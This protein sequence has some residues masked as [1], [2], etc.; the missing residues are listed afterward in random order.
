VT[1]RRPPLTID[2]ALTRIADHLPGGWREMAEVAHRREGLVRAWGDPD[3]REGIPLLDSL[4]LDLA[5]RA[6][7]GRG[8]PLFEWYTARLDAAGGLR[9]AGP[10][11]LARQAEQL[12]RE[13]GEAN[14][15]LIAVSFSGG[16]HAKL[17]AARREIEEAMVALQRA[18]I[19]L[20]GR[21]ALAHIL[22]EDEGEAPPSPPDTEGH[23][24]TGPP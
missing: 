23:P 3:R 4:Q 21:E 10:A 7:G 13:C 1:K 6:G 17:V 16:D 5:Y 9:V 15:A 2:A 22:D 24:S 8:A 14:A 11:A 19:M 12:V 20:G 18:R